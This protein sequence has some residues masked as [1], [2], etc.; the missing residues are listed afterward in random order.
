M[1]NVG[2]DGRSFTVGEGR[3]DRMIEDAKEERDLL[4]SQREASQ[5]V[6]D[7]R[8]EEIQRQQAAID[9]YNRQLAEY[10]EIQKQSQDALAEQ[11][12]SLAAGA[13]G[14][15]I[16]NNYYTQGGTNVFNNTSMSKTSASN[17]TSYAL[18]YGGGSNG[19]PGFI[20]IPGLV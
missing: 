11:M 4:Q 12:D 8:L 5:N 7:R 20:A 13:G 14:N 16:M 19:G 17:V 15:P 3:L 1:F 18:G 6:I 2:T 10:N 9:E